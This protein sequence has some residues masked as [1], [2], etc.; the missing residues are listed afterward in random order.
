MQ[1]PCVWL[2]ISSVPSLIGAVSDELLQ[3]R[4]ENSI[5]ASVQDLWFVAGGGYK[6]LLVKEDLWSLLEDHLM[7]RESDSSW[8]RP[9]RRWPDGRACEGLGS[10]SAPCLAPDAQLCIDQLLPLLFKEVH[11]A[12]SFI[13]TQAEVLHA[14]AQ[15]TGTST[16][17][18]MPPLFGRA[19]AS[20][21]ALDTTL[22][23]F[24]AFFERMDFNPR[25]AA[26]L[27][28]VMGQKMRDAVML[29]LEDRKVLRDRLEEMR[30]ELAAFGR[31]AHARYGSQ[32]H[33]DTAVFVASKAEWAL[34]HLVRLDGYFADQ[35]G[36]S[37]V[38]LDEFTPEDLLEP[39]DSSVG[40]T[41]WD[42]ELR[43]A[44]HLE[45]EF[46]H[47]D[48]GLLRYLLRELLVMDDVVCDLGAFGGHYSSWLNDTGLVT[49][50]AFDG[51]PRVE[52]LTQGRVRYAPLQEAKELPVPCDVVLCLEVLEHIPRQEE[53]ISLENLGRLAP[54]VLVA[55]WAPP[56]VPGPGHVNQ[57]E[58]LEA[59]QRVEEVTGLQ[60]NL[61]L[62][63]SA[64]AHSEIPWIKESVAI[65]LAPEEKKHPRIIN[66][67]E[68]PSSE[69]L[70]PIIGIG[71]NHC[72]VHLGQDHLAQLAVQH[73][74][75]YIL[76]KQCLTLTAA[77]PESGVA[78]LFVGNLPHDAD[79]TQV[80]ALLS[81]CGPVSDVRLQRDAS[82]GHTIFG[83]VDFLHP[84]D[85][86]K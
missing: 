10:R 47:L 49:A 25:L 29:A 12:M 76:R 34:Y 22:D 8:E 53:L 66:L 65:F 51:T 15:I 61:Q 58:T 69:N 78:T 33:A 23:L 28:T 19:C 62:T 83:F 42:L 63:A 9:P 80:S 31:L 11:H 13:H 3:E 17:S 38:N 59:W 43:T 32:W 74:Q 71:A 40:T 79:E 27:S 64:Q 72:F 24:L 82:D 36:L 77:S 44:L 85:G 73:L 1:L 30:W 52:E 81:A 50:Y 35:L 54:R 26:C 45:G 39:L 4:A 16:D 55:S 56:H 7:I 46:W 21:H 41:D 2:V 57:R 86:K 67:F 60:R 70:T 48:K 75:N 14:V 18:M 5:N 6:P 37:D 68:T 20:A 84:E